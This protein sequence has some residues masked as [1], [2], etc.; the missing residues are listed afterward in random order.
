MQVFNSDVWLIDIVTE[1]ALY[2]LHKL[3]GTNTWFVFCCRSF[4]EAAVRSSEAPKLVRNQRGD[5][6]ILQE[7]TWSSRIWIQETFYESLFQLV[8]VS[9]KIFCHQNKLD[10]KI[11]PA[12]VTVSIQLLVGD[13]RITSI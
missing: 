3:E 11:G 5:K 10:T 7:G 4:V 8:V 2:Q 1:T 9:S 6:A 13:L 12:A